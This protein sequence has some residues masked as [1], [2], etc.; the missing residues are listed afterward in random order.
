MISPEARAVLKT[1]GAGALVGVVIVGLG[2]LLG[3]LVPPSG[4]QRIEVIVRFDG[5]I[6]VQMVPR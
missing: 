6:Q 4:P 5:P 2:V 3:S 1:V